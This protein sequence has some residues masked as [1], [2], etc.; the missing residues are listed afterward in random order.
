MCVF[1][2]T[3][4]KTAKPPEKFDLKEKFMEGNTAPANQEAR[5]NKARSQGTTMDDCL[6]TVPNT[7]YDNK[8]QISVN[9]EIGNV[10]EARQSAML[11]KQ[12]VLKSEYNIEVLQPETNVEDVDGGKGVGRVANEPVGTTRPEVTDTPSPGRDQV[13]A[14]QRILSARE[15]AMRNRDKVLAH[16]FHLD[17]NYKGYGQTEKSKKKIVCFGNVAVKLDVGSNPS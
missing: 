9:K 14:C 5:D 11:I 8:A 2:I 17:A 1:L 4:K 12:K 6:H 7:F 13:P 16:E 15:E 10:L 3:G